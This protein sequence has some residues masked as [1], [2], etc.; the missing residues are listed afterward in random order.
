MYCC[1][2]SYGILHSLYAAIETPIWR[3]GSCSHAAHFKSHGL[4]NGCLVPLRSDSSMLML[5]LL[6]AFMVPKQIIVFLLPNFLR[7]LGMIPRNGQLAQQSGLTGGIGCWCI[8]SLGIF[9]QISGDL[10][11][12]VGFGPK[13]DP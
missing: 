4:W 13:A 2:C 8:V 7:L 1:C 11:T 12:S 6:I 10:Y 9:I 5:S 3:L